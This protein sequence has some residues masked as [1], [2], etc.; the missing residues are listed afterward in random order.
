MYIFI[1]EDGELFFGVNYS[2]ED[3]DAVSAGI[4]QILD[5]SNPEKPMDM[6]PT[7]EGV[8]WV[9]IRNWGD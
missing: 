5:I 9:E 1:M 6:S 4:L 8:E 2:Q 7:E 3:I